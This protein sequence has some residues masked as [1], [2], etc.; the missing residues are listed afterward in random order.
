MADEQARP[1]WALKIEEDFDLDYIERALL[2]AAEQ[3]WHRWQALAR[4]IDDEGIMLPGRYENTQRAHPLLASEQVARQ[5]FMRALR[6][7][8]M[9]G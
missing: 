5:A 8:K 7:L 3:A 9:D 2:D 1:A 4:R 6:A